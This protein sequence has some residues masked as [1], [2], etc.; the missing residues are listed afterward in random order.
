MHANGVGHY[1]LVVVFFIFGRR[2]RSFGVQ[3]LEYYFSCRQDL[4]SHVDQLCC[5]DLDD[6]ATKVTMSRALDH[7]RRMFMV[8]Q[9]V[10]ACQAL[11][12]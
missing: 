2:F 10:C 4:F 3:E 5:F 7:A 8:L 9:V 1:K 11:M 12:F 6:S